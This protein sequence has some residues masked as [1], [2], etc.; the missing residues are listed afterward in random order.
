MHRM[1]IGLIAAG[2][3]VAFTALFFLTVSSKLTVAVNREVEDRVARAQRVQQHLGRLGGGGFTNIAM[4]KPPRP[5]VLAAA[6][7]GD[8]TAR[9]Q[10]AFEE[11]E[12]INAAL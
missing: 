4:D 5:G 7:K 3:L 11:C 2:L 9:R 8:E 10:A 1:R 12:V 6:S